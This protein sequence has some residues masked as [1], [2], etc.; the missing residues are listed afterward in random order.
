V[1]IPLD[2]PS[3]ANTMT[4]QVNNPSES[5]SESEGDQYSITVSQQKIMAQ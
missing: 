5:E 2:S 3:I 1:Y 4:Q